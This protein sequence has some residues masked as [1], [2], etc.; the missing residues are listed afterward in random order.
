MRITVIFCIVTLY[1]LLAC[2]E[3]RYSDGQT[4]YNNLCARCHMEDGSG[5]GEA[6]PALTPERLELR[7]AEIPCL[8]KHGIKGEIMDMPAQAQ[9]NAVQISNIVHYLFDHLAKKPVQIPLS[10]IE[11]TLNNCPQRQ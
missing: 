3:S 9:L 1:L 7:K 8:I 4:M 6:I 10:D 11:A 2:N 5:L